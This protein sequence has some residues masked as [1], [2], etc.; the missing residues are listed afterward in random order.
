MHNPQSCLSVDFDEFLKTGFHL[1]E[2]LA[3]YLQLSIKD[4]EKLLPQSS[5]DLASL[6]PG[7]FNSDNATS[8]YEDEVGTA[9]LLELAAWHLGS[10][11]YILDTLRLQ[12]MFAHGQVLD[13]GGGIGTHALAAAAMKQVDHVWFVDLNPNNR[14]FVQQRASLLGL[15]DCISFHRDLKSAGEIVFDTIVCLDVLEHLAD[16]SA[17]IIKFHQRLSPES[18]AI[19]N[20]Y[21]FKGFNGEY[22]FHFDDPSMINSFFKVLQNKF[23]EVFHPYLITTRVY[24]P[25]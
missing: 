8:F 6:H 7:G 16:P 4:I 19:L 24:K 11:D 1:K 13:F 18:V 22:P 15:S 21:F 2:H 10:A 12:Q 17:Q 25:I 14:K 20:W 3:Q 5:K 23:I 9:H